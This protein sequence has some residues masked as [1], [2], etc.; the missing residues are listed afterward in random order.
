MQVQILKN[1][2]VS[3]MDKIL[4]SSDGLLQPV[5][6][7]ELIGLPPSHLMIWGNKNGVYTYPTIELIDWIKN[8]INGRSAIEICSGTG[9]I[10]RALKIP[11]TDSYIQ[12]TP[13]MILWYL[14]SHQKPIFPAPDVHKFEAN[15]AVDY[16]KPEVVVGCYVTQKYLTGDEGPPLI[17][18][19]LNGVDE[20]Q[21]LPK[22]K[23]YINIGNYSTH[24]DKRI[25][26]KYKHKVYK[27][28]WLLT[29]SVMP[30]D[31]EIVVWEI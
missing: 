10:G 24:K 4:L 27:F 16:F 7:S 21:M 31:N 14:A 25:R 19:S 22:I 26:I 11:F 15:E 8:Q 18:S 17:G 2:D 12:T 5:N 23:T 30:A 1:E 3:Y 9:V 6:S 28:P 29:R 13:E 20:L